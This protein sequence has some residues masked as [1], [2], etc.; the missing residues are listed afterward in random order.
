[1]RGMP[2]AYDLLLKLAYLALAVGAIAIYLRRRKRAEQA[3]ADTLAQAS[4]AGLLEPPS[5]HPVIDAARCVGSG[6]CVTACPEEA[7]GIVGGK[8]LL[9]NPSICIGH[10]ACFAACPVGAIT[11]V[12]GT[13]RRGID[14]PYVKPDFESNVP[15]LYIAG[16]LGGMGLIRKAAEQGS[17]AVASVA[18]RRSGR[19]ALDVVIVGAGPAGIAAGLAAIEHGLRYRLIEQEADLGGSV[20]HYPRNKVAMT[21]PVKLPVVGRMR[22]TEVSKEKLL[23]FWQDVVARAGLEVGFGERMEGLARVADHF[24]LRTTRGSYE[25][26]AVVLAIG[27]RG[28]PRKLEVPGEES[29]KVV[30][31]LVDAEQYAG[32]NVLVVGG[33][34]SAVEAALACA[35]AGATVHLSYRGEAFNRLKP[36]NRARLEQATARRRVVV[37]LGSNV[38]AIHADRVELEGAQG[39]RTLP[40]DAVIVCAGGVLPTELLRSAGIA[41]ETKHG[42]A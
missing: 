42:Q 34:D 4:A 8:A 9:A 16:E 41:F 5:L 6:A 20:Y 21:A 25:T 10:G 36:A 39:A 12:F 32:R 19:S 35:E 27:R 1:M 7:L 22:F 40:N 28:S 13:E 24:V 38:R 33:G 31:R 14:I 29:A 11:L 18:R 23:T 26:D 30:Y 3:H 17:Q 15:G 2:D 37:A